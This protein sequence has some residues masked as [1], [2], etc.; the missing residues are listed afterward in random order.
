MICKK[1][2]SFLLIFGLALLFARESFAC[3]PC[4]IFN[5]SRL[6]GHQKDSLTFAVSQQLTTFKRKREE[7][8]LAVSSGENLRAFSTTQFS[9]NYDL[10]ERLGLQFSLPLIGRNYWRYQNFRRDR[11]LDIGIGDAVFLTNYTF[12]EKR[13]LNF[14]GSLS[15]SFGVKLPT[16]DTG[17]LRD[18][19]SGNRSDDPLKD[20]FKHHQ[21]GA[22]SGGRALSLGSGSVDYILGVNSL[23]R[24][25]RALLLSRLQYGV[26]TEG[27]FNYRFANDLI[28]SISTGYFLSADHDLTLALLLSVSGEFKN[29]D[30]LRGGFV[31]GSGFS[32]IYFGPELL[33]T[34]KKNLG[35]ELRFEARATNPDPAAEIIPAERYSVSFFYRF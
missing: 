33:L 1:Y 13:G 18:L 12:A 34:Y 6:Q 5:A 15:A 35:A 28:A 29:K 16:G 7:R 9:V 24:Y 4:A 26:R 2:R 32:N 25:K 3:D 27:D 17:V 31:D 23:T 14:N 10:N 21:I 30:K 8:S 11:E 20:G 19:A 22:A